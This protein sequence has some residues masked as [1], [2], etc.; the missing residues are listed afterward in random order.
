MSL[1]QAALLACKEGEA[2]WAIHS[3]SSDDV[4]LK[5]IS[6]IFLCST[7]EV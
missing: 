1:V 4:K 5:T 6:A 2:V 7:R 3:H